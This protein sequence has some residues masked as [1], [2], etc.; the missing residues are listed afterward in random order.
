MNNIFSVYFSATYTTRKITREITAQFDGTVREYDITAD[1]P[2]STITLDT[3]DTLIVGMPVYAGRIPAPAAETLKR[4]KGNNTPAV[5]TVVYGNRE[6]DD[7]LLELKDIVESNGFKVVSAAAFIAQHSIFPAMAAG[8]PDDND[9]QAIR[10]F[11]KQSRELA[12]S[13]I[14]ELQPLE[15]KGNRPYKIPKPIPLHPKGNS[16]CNKCGK[17]VKQCPA[18]AISPDYPQKTDTEKCISCGHC[19]V[20]CHRHSRRFRGLLYSLV[21]RKFTKAYS[22]RKEPEIWYASH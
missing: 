19:I 17:C 12:I 11:G 13:D 9:M 1:I 16:R 18:K 6:Y 22:S 8:R 14:S 10:T 4:F 15:V 21:C 2:D 3:A 20:V 7:A 5:I